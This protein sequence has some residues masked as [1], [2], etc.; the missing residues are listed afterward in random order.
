MIG[1]YGLVGTV[2]ALRNLSLVQRK[3]LPELVSLDLL[4]NPPGVAVPVHYVFGEQ[5]ALTDAAIWKQLPAAIA[6]P[7]STVNVVPEAGHMVHFDQPE[8]VRSIAMS[9]INDS[10]E[11]PAVA[12]A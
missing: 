2:K 8:V 12:H 6:A 4:T 11:I 10:R 5:D 9:A 1:A 7:V 3:L